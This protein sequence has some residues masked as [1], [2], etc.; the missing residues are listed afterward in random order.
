MEE[1]KE[2][3]IEP[4]KPYRPEPDL[5][6]STIIVNPGTSFPADI[7]KNKDGSI[8]EAELIK[9][10]NALNEGRI[11]FPGAYHENRKLAAWKQLAQC[12]TEL[13]L[14]VPQLKR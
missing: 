13:G 4:I 14:E 2:A 6:L 9:A 8:N 3:K 1:K 10:M 11:H 7:Y 12:F 5:A